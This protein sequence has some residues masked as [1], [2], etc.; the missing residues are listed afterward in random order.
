MK[1][2]YKAGRPEDDLTVGKNY[3]VI[4]VKCKK[5][6]EVSEVFLKNDKEE[7]R[8]YS[9]DFFIMYAEATEAMKT[10]AVEAALGAGRLATPDPQ[11]IIT[12]TADHRESHGLDSIERALEA[13]KIKRDLGLMFG[14]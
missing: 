14:A 4:E 12:T 7:E 6:F 8:W 1:A 2:Q 10:A 5:G 13:Q 11:I 3:D 9:V